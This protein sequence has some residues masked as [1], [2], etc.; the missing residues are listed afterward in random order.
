MKTTYNPRINEWLL[1]KSTIFLNHGSFG[2]CPIEVFN[3]YQQW[4]KL[5]EQQP[6]KFF[7]YTL[8][9]ELYSA[10]KILSSFLNV[11]TDDLVFVQNATEGVNTVLH[12]IQWQHDDEILI[13][14]HI[15]PACRNAIQFY[16]NRF[17]VKV[18]EVQILFPLNSN[19][20]IIQTIIDTITNKTRLILLD[21]IASP[22]GL[23]FPIKEIRQQISNDI[24][25]LVDGA[26]APGAISLDIN[27]LGVDFYTGNCHK[28]MCSPKGAG[29]LWIQAKHQDYI[30]PINISLINTVSESFNERFFWRG[31]Q[32]PSA[33]LSIPAAISFLN[34]ISNNNIN[35]FINQNIKMNRK[36]REIVS[37]QLQIPML[38]PNEMIATMSAIP[39]YSNSSE[40]HNNTIDPMQ[41][42]L[43]Q[44]YNIEVPIFNWA[45]EAYKLLRFSY[46]AYNDETQYIT[47]AN[48]I[49][50]YY[51]H[52]NK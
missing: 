4:Q 10:K 28:W 24:L 23:L 25:I 47:L 3:K 34:K 6:V 12:S 14:N 22:T 38:C 51:K 48:A 52:L 40:T 42:W 29:F 18:K 1:D 11:Q 26:H 5:I 39:I 21:H 41:E 15:Y 43:M 13:T 9:E 36:M 7:M 44:K 45:N 33:W 32:D 2:A 30:Y 20:E 27:E 19:D 50:E 8:R 16:A 37:Q 49:L 17:G 46:F 35:T 31:T